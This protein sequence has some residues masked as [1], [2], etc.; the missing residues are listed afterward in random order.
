MF[1]KFTMSAIVASILMTA[2]SAAMAGP[3]HAVRHQTTIQQIPANAYLSF[4][5]VRSTR[6]VN[7]PGNAKIQDIGF[8]ENLGD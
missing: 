5:A 7:V 6:S 4:G 8:K 3:K 2:G 1:N